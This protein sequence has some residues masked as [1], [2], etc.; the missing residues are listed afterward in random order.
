MVKMLRWWLQK[1][2]G[3]C[4]LSGCKQRVKVSHHISSALSL[5]TGVP[6]GCV[7]SPL[8]YSLYTYDCRPVHPS[9]N[10]MK[11]ADDTTG[12][13]LISGGDESTYTNEVEQLVS[14]CKTNNLILNISK[15]KEL[16]KDFRRKNTV[17]TPNYKGKLC[18]E[19]G[20][21]SFSGSPHGRELVLK[22]K[23]L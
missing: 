19:G 20:G 7:L 15:N 9:N 17:F 3:I 21:L 10:F 13:G 22:Y 12:V 8:L 14:W 5:S 6:Q 2:D 11:Y 1:H 18:G 4:F 16:I 23:Y